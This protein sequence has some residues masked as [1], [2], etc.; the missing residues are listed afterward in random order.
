MAHV[1]R[2][3][4]V[5]V[6]KGREKGK[7][8]KVKRVHAKGRVEIEKIMMVKRHTR[9]TQK[10]PQGGIVDKEGTVALANVALFCEKCGKG[11][12]AGVRVDEGG[13]KVRVCKGCQTAF[14]APGV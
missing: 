5:I 10:N 13:R 3:D 11:R 7:R 14:P 1:C 4:V 2:G 8:G 9:P 6:T 12:R